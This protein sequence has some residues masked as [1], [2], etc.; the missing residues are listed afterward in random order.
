MS[1]TFWALNAICSTIL[2][3]CQYTASRNR[4]NSA[5]RHDPYHFE[6]SSK[7]SRLSNI[8]EHFPPNAPLET[9]I[10]RLIGCFIPFTLRPQP[11]FE[12]LLQGS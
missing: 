12:L 4:I 7:W 9:K 2:I 1:L 3:C 11:L 6:V 10:L 8:A 5:D